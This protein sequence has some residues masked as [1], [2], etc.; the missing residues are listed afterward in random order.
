MRQVGG[1]LGLLLTVAVVLLSGATAYVVL[2]VRFYQGYQNAYASYLIDPA[3]ACGALL[4]WNPPAA[5]YTAFY[6]NQPNLLQVRYRSIH[7]ETLRLSLSITGL[8]QEQS[9]DV[10]SGSAFNTQSFKPPLSGPAVLDSL[11]GPRTRDAQIVLSVR[12]ATS[13]QACT[14]SQTVRLESR[15]VMQWQD[16]DGH[17]Q[18][19]YLAGWVTPQADVVGTLVGRTADRLTQNAATYPDASALFGYNGGQASARAVIEQVDAL[20]DTLQN[21]YHVHYVDENVPYQQNTTQLIQLPKDVLSGPAPTAMCVET[22]AIMASAVERMG[23]RPYI[24]IV[25]GHAFLGVALGPSANAPIE[26]WET[27]LLNGGYTGDQANAK[28]DDEAA[29]TYHGKVLRVIDIESER[30]QGIEPME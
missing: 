28:G 25:P 11:V 27:S 13:Q 14:A 22:T 18:S 16:G 10:R 7:P 1:R 20:F 30:Q 6:G 2:G 26:Y 21:A 15:Q 23:M 29:N 5:I 19:A 8:T 12:S 3:N 17:D 9:V 24:V 4:T